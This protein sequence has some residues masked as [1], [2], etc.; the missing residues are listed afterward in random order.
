[1]HPTGMQ[2]CYLKI[3]KALFKLA[4]AIYNLNFK[5]K[6]DLSVRELKILQVNTVNDSLQ[7]SI[8]IHLI[9]RVPPMLVST[10]ISMWIQKSSVAMLTVKSSV[11]VRV[12]CKTAIA[13]RQ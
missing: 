13:H 3:H 7:D 1:M 9:L 10:C 5:Y 12:E 6:L 8:E 4:M 11:G 2:S